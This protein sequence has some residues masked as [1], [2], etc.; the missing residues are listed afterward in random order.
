MQVRQTNK[1]VFLILFQYFATLALSS[2][3]ITGF[4]FLQNV[5]LL[6]VEF[7]VDIAVVC[8]GESRPSLVCDQ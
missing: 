6:T 5:L 8:P 2:Y 1:N 7:A 4:E 3:K